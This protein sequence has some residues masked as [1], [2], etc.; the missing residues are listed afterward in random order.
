[1]IYRAVL[2]KDCRKVDVAI[3]TIKEKKEKNRF[4]HEMAMMSR[5]VHS[6]IIEFHGVV[7]EGIVN[8]NSQ[9]D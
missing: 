5:L 1:M 9:Q 2:K 3:K 7:R 4:M 6:N 8:S